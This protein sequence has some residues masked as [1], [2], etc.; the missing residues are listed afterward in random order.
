MPVGQPDAF[1][2]PPTGQPAGFPQQIQPK[3]SKLRWLRFAIP[4]LV[5]V[6]SAGAFAVN[7]FTGTDGAKVGDCLVVSEFTSKADPKQADCAGAEA[8]VKVAAKV[9]EN[10]SCPEGT[11]DEYSQTGRISYKLCLMVNAKQGD[12]L[13]NFTSAT[14][15]YKKVPCSDP[16]KD[17]EF[18]KVVDGQADRALCEGTEATNALTFSTPPTTMCV[19]KAG[20]A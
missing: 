17:A 2:P 15:G 18:V 6:L 16:A 13:A 20:G 9:D 3:K 19:I 10:A 1:G 12:C 5:V 8:N 4:V 14:S 11:Y 7:Y